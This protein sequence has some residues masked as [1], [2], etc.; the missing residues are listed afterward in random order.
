MA[1]YGLTYVQIVNRVLERLRESTVSNYN[2]SDYSKLIAHLVNQVKSEIEEA[3]QWHALRNTFSISPTTDVSHYALT[4]SGARAKIIDGW[5]TTQGLRLTKGTNASFNSKF[6]GVG[7]NSV[8]TG[9]PTMYLPAG[10]D[11]N[12]DIAV[13][14]WPIPVT[15]YLDT[16]KFNVYVPQDDLAANATVPLVPQH[17]LLE[18]VIARALLE[19]GE[20]GAPQLVPGETFIMKELL[21]SAISADA[22]DDMT[23]LDWETE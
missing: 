2:D 13:D 12:L 20:E 11:A 5:N 16:L 15:G 22:G 9:S 18:E 23:E 7:S 6:F 3:W 21:A 19:K 14:V 8:Q 17:V 10:L 4:D 1:A